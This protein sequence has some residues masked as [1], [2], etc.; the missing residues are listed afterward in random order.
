MF[1]ITELLDIAIRIEKNGEKAYRAAS[2]KVENE[3]VGSLLVWLSEQEAI[4]TAFFSSLKDAAPVS[5]DPI[6]EENLNGP[7][8][9]QLMEG[10][11]F[12]LSEINFLT[13]TQLYELIQ[14]AIEFERD[15]ILFYEL[16]KSFIQDNDAK[17]KLDT[18]IQEERQHIQKLK[19]L[20]P[21]DNTKGE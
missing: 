18:I 21:D 6:P 11:S 12:S 9:D 17:D 4:H 20:M 16:L 19:L 14:I 1:T 13:I 2:Q 15:T 5:P 10:K 7:L 8:I 3:N